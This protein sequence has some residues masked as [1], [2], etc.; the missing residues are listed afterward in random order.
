MSALFVA[1]SLQDETLS[2]MKTLR[3]ITMLKTLMI[4]AAV[5]A[6]T[7]SG[8]FAQ[9]TPPAS[10]PASPPVATA[11]A[12]PKFVASQ[13]A[14]QWI[15]SKFKGTD[16]IGPDSAFIGDVNDVLFDKNGKILAL[17]V[18]VGGFLGIG[19]KSVAIDMSAFEVAPLDAG[20]TSAGV[21]NNDPTN[22]RLKVSWT[23][24]QLKQAPDFEYYKPPRP[25][26]STPSPTTG[27]GQRPTT[28]QR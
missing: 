25:A 12:S 23:K 3:R 13:S 10:P 9:A 26:A 4:S 2:R 7:V 24:E 16:V 27:M 6:L 17:I 1:I 5:S 14:D 18:G 28:P 15:F 21:S 20:N 22:V 11:P 8:A 19:E